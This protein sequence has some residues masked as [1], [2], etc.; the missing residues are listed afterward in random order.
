MK[1]CE[2]RKTVKEE[3]K[4]IGKEIRELKDSRKQGKRGGRPLYRIQTDIWTLKYDY[5]HK[6]IAYCMFFNHRTLEQVE[7]TKSERYTKPYMLR[8]NS[9]IECWSKEVTCEKALCNCA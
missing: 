3:L 5:R 6:H 7:S 8:V 9:Q 1:K 2:V 4:A